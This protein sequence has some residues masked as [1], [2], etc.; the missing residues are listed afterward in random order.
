MLTNLFKHWTYRVFAPGAVLRTTYEAFQKL[1]SFDSRSHEMMADLESLYYQG[2]K[3]DFYKISLKYEALSKNVK[4]MVDSLEQMAPGSYVDLPAYYKKFDFYSRFFLAPPKLNFGEPFVL[5][6]SDKELSNEYTGSKTGT[7]VELSRSLN[8]TIPAGFVIT[9]NCFSYLLEYNNLRPAINAL[10]GETDLS[11]VAHLSEISSNIKQ[12]ISDAEIPPD[13]EKAILAAQDLLQ[14]ESEKSWDQLC[15]VR[16]SALS[17]DGQCSFAGQYSSC[18]NV[19][20]DQLIA[21]YIEVLCSKYSPEALAYRINCGLSD[22]ET[23]MAVMV[24]QMVEAAAAGVV[25]TSDPSG[26]REDE[27]FVHS[28]KGLGDSVVSG[29][30]IPEVFSVSKEECQLTCAPVSEDKSL[31]EDQILDLAEKSIR[32]EHH[33]NGPQDIEWAMQKDGSFVFLQSRD[34]HVYGHETKADEKVAVATDSMLF[35]GGKMASSGAIC[36]KAWCL[37]AETSIDKIGQGDIL[38]IRETLPSYVRVLHQVS[39]VIA[40]LGS[41]A[42]HFATVCRE[43][44]V[45]LLLGVG[46]D[47]HCIKH[48]QLITLSA[49]T[50]A[51][52]SGNTLHSIEAVPVYKQ[53]KDL[54]FFKKLR[55]V[56]DFV[57]PLNLLDPKS[58]TFLPDSCRSLHDIIRFSHEMAVQTMFSISERC[59]TIKGGKKKLQTQLPFEVYL[60]DVDEG[61]DKSVSDLDE[62]SVDLIHSVPFKA[63]WHGLNHSDISWGEQIHYDWKGYD[64]M[65]MSDAFAFQS[66]FDSA[67]Y[68]VLGKYYLNIN[69]RFG[70]HFTMIDALCEPGSTTSY[71]TM[72]FAGGGGEFEGRELRITFLETILGRLGFD[73]EIKGDLLDAR[74]SGIS[75]DILVERIESL[76]KLL[77][78]T[79][80][81]DM[82]LKSL[83]MVDEQIERFFQVA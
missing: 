67:S 48:G 35:C 77:G 17:E 32:I 13:V 78:L 33:F 66:S 64:R 31:T 27:L 30:V 49:D 22:E 23:P 16:S 63:L 4:G 74:L 1:L 7:L 80:Q 55:N 41:A 71:C 20:P 45:P 3:E 52:Y 60:V 56:L 12:L 38:V 2:K 28:T 83:E 10:L 54:P 18:L 58:K 61:L 6:F 39:G 19:K 26:S 37:E 21:A 46:K 82:H 73:V 15:A 25:Y 9:T 51:V 57:T 36:A 81:M 76:G 59:S 70:Y 14:K 47:I 43:F 5:Q 68:A 11:A 53:N 29:T 75:S 72:R 65:V 50:N 8:L 44:G 69:I 42:G 79:K 40:E 24:L 62:I 34:L